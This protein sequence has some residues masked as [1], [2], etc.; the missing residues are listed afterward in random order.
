MKTSLY[1]GQ[2]MNHGIIGGFYEITYGTHHGKQP[3]LG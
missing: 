1:S 3:V 2:R